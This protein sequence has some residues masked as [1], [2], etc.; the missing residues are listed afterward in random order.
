MSLGC[1]VRVRDCSG[2]PCPIFHRGRL[3]R[4]ARPLARLRAG[5]NAP[6]KIC[7]TGTGTKKIKNEII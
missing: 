3:Q 6:K 7:R 2:N 1:V 4:K 5:G